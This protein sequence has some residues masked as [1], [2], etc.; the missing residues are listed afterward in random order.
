MYIQHIQGLCQFRLSR[1]EN[2]LLV[3]APATSRIAVQ[4]LERS[5]AWPSPSLSPVYFELSIQVKVKVMLRPTVSRPV[6]LGVKHPS[7]A[8][9]QIFITVR[10]L[11]VCWCGVLSLT[12]ERVYRLQLLLVLTSAVILGSWSRGIHNHI[13]LSQIRDSPNLEGQVPIFISPRNRVAQLYPQALGSLFVASYDSQG[14]GEGITKV[15]VMLRPTVQSASLSWNKA[16][17]WGLRPDLYYWTVNSVRVRESES[18]CDWRSVSLSVLVSSPVWGSWPD[19]NY[20]LTVTVLS[21]GGAPF[22]T[23]GNCQLLLASRY[24]ASGRTTAQTTH[25]LPS[26]GY[27]WTH[28]ENTSCNTGSI[29]ACV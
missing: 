29:V 7:G 3:V 17:I 18:H 21:L 4:S 10:E 15:K 12:R 16:P 28:T 24:I 2:A 22:L 20:C 23:G 6:C 14:Y 25:P 13:L 19:I 11:Q 8:Y 9:D 5:Y 26:N 1:A 27:M